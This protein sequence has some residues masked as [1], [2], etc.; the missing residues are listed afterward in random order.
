MATVETMFAR[1]LQLLPIFAICFGWFC[2]AELTG[3]YDAC[4]EDVVPWKDVRH[5]IFAFLSGRVPQEQVMELKEIALTGGLTLGDCDCMWGWITLRFFVPLIMEPDEVDRFLKDQ[6]FHTEWLVFLASA[7]TELFES[8]WDVM[9]VLAA[10]SDRHPRLNIP[11][12]Q[13]GCSGT[14]R[15]LLEVISNRPDRMAVT[16]SEEA[17]LSAAILL[18]LP[19]E[20]VESLLGHDTAEIWADPC[21]PHAIA[22]AALFLG[23]D[24]DGFHVTAGYG[25]RLAAAVLRR[26]SYFGF[27]AFLQSPW[28]IPQLLVRAQDLL[29]EGA[30][31]DSRLLDSHT[32]V[33]RAIKNASS[34][35]YPG[36]DPTLRPQANTLEKLRLFHGLAAT[37]AL[38]TALKV[39]YIAITGTLLGAARHHNFIPWDDDGDVCA[40][41][42]DEARL[43]AAALLQGPGRHEQKGP[44]A[45][46]YRHAA[47]AKDSSI[48]NAMLALHEAGFELH[49][50][51]ARPLIFKISGRAWPRVPGKAFGYPYVDIWFCHNWETGEF[52]QMSEMYGVKQLREV[53]FPR[54]KILLAGLPMWTFRQYRESLTQYYNTEDW[55]DNCVGHVSFHREE[56]KLSVEQGRVDCSSLRDRFAFA[57]TEPGPPEGIAP[58]A[59]FAAVH[60]WLR[61]HRQPTWSLDPDG[62]SGA[63]GNF[64]NRE[65]WRRARE[66]GLSQLRLGAS[67]ELQPLRFEALNSSRLEGP[68]GR[69]LH[70]LL[71]VTLVLERPRDARCDLIIRLQPLVATGFDSQLLQDFVAPSLVGTLGQ[72]LLE[73]S[74]GSAWRFDIPSCVC[75]FHLGSIALQWVAEDSAAHSAE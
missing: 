35:A 41:I 11:E 12:A 68:G 57:S 13:A 23:I 4:H 58:D 47:A 42:R 38:L 49:A 17:L 31:Q 26:S 37:H 71:E 2:T 5:S 46:E 9:M 48:A 18:E 27:G 29:R 28:P 65:T 36:L 67:S 70:H 69:V 10:T 1:V 64:N 40:N 50:H 8:P 66:E 56:R 21:Q 62:S 20:L 72:Q 33:V 44:T 55:S 19:E 32:E 39:P 74:D 51:M 22:T 25:F 54:R 60:A 63:E 75:R 3:S 16:G 6:M 7:W 24:S 53:V 43:L 15:R 59:V 14:Q 52:S 34:E 73:A 61:L 30:R 45:S